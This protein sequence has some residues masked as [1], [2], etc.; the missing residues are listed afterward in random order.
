MTLPRKPPWLRKKIVFDQSRP[1]AAI[2]RDLELNTVCREAKCPNISECF[3]SRQAT[4]LILGKSC[5]RSCRFC[6]VDKTIPR[7]PDPDEPRR[8]GEAV[9]RLGLKHAVVTSVTRDDLT[10]GGSHHFAQTILEIRKQGRFP[11][12]PSPTIEVL[13][14]DFGGDGGALQTVV[15][16]KPDVLGHDVETVPRLYRLRPGAD[17]LRSLS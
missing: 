6:H 11:N 15:A 12:A 13:I 1:T 14:P 10:D 5:T 8:V 7:P 4:F 9:R 2:L 17:Y 3:L 16:A